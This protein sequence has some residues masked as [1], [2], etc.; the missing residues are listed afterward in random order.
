[1]NVNPQ[2]A[3][4]RDVLAG[5]PTHEL[6]ARLDFGRN[7]L[8]DVVRNKENIPLATI[9]EISRQLKII[10]EVLQD[11]GNGLVPNTRG[12]N[13]RTFPRGQDITIAMKPA[14]IFPKSPL[15]LG[16]R[17]GRKRIKEIND[18]KDRNILKSLAKQQTD[19]LTKNWK[20]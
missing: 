9:L 4:D 15:Q 8:R 3:I 18:K 10:E 7:V 13:I 16:K 17:G 6:N 20:K 12:S 1:M 14:V 19:R 2:D 5:F 11:R